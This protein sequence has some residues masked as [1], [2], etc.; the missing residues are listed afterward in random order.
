MRI[1]VLKPPSFFIDEMFGLDR[2]SHHGGDESQAF[3][4]SVVIPILPET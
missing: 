4:F 1:L 2:L 3:Q